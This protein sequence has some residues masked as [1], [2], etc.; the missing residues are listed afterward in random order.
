MARSD[1]ELDD[2][3]LESLD[4]FKNKVCGLYK[5]NKAKL[6]EFL[7][8]LMDE[9]DALNSENCMLKDECTQLKRDIKELEQENRVLKSERIEI[10][11]KNLVLHEDL[12]RIKETLNLKE[13][14]FVIELTRL[15]KVSLELKQRMES[16]LVDNKNLHA[17]L[18]QVETDFATNRCW[19]QASQ[20]LNCLSKNHNHSKK[21]LGFRR[22][23]TD[24]PKNRKYVGLLENIVCFHCGKTS[25]VRY[26]FP[27]RNNAM[28]RNLNHVKQIWVGKDEIFM[29]NG[30][31]PKWIWVPKTSP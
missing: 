15:E 2:E 6:K 28:E 23:H 31:G 29:S 20:A 24:H 19:N 26:T 21:G 14:S 18:K 10:D 27:S 9:Y 13:E 8:T 12:E 1:I 17:K 16:L 7:F 25:H 3:S 22:K 30:K 5:A 4:Q 11:I